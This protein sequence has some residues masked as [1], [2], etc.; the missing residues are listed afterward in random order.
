MEI[1][2]QKEGPKWAYEGFKELAIRAAKVQFPSASDAFRR[3]MAESFARRRIRFEYLKEHQK[4]RAV[5]TD[6][7]EQD[8]H[9]E[10]QPEPEGGD[11]PAPLVKKQEVPK[12]ANIPVRRRLQDQHTIY[13]ATEITKLDLR[14]EPRQQERAES[15]ASVALRNSGFPPPPKTSGG[16]FLCPYCRLEFRAREAEKDRWK[17]VVAQFQTMHYL[18][19]RRV[20]ASTSCKISN[21]TSAP[22]KIAKRRLTYRT[23]LMVY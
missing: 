15:V 13:S 4:K 7:Q 6:V 2:R 8:S 23:R 20:T 10:P 22:S 5:D 16:S 12:R 17:W 21:R 18:L 1:Y 19:I 14:P 9:R 3:R 11:G